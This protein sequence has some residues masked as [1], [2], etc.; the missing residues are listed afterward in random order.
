MPA[1]TFRRP[2]R[3][4]QIGCAALIATLVAACQTSGDALPEPTGA[5]ALPG[6]EA[7]LAPSGGSAAQGSAK[8]VDRGEGAIVALVVINNVTPGIYRVAIHERGN[9]TSPNAFSAGRPW[10]PPGSAVAAGDLLPEIAIGPNGNAQMT[11]RLRGLALRGPNGLEGRSV[12]VHQGATV[13][14]DIVPDR[15]NRVVL[16]GAIGAVRSFLDAIR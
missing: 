6:V 10:A 2:H 12:L 5:R 9:C 13:D 14:A 16:C 15:P 7:P 8:F 1:R 11:T 3:V 4:A